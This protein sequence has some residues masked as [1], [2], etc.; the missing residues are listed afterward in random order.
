MLLQIPSLFSPEE[1]REFRAVL[2]SAD[3][4]DGRI[5]AGH[6][7][8]KVKDNLQLSEMDP[9]A[10]LLGDRIIERLASTPLYI[11]A[12][13]PFRIYPPRFNRYEGG[14]TYGN[15]VDNAIFPI[16]GTP[17]RLRTD[18][19]TTIFFSDPDEYEGGDLVIED[20]Y[21][22]Q[23]VKLAA[24]DMVLYP[25]SSLHRVEPVTKGTRYAS[26][27]WTQS[28]VRSTENRRML[29]EL[30]CSI[31]AITAD[32]AGHEGLDGLTNVYHNLLRQWSET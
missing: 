3:W 11:A 7:A 25:G 9:T 30:D 28:L 12:A 16:P 22:E 1:V 26:F 20:T 27:F 18:L 32:H 5:T 29:F 21:G 31:Q 6:R 24:G 4:S 13:L 19:S 10:N 17:L 15:H 14:G 23:R 2:E 8:A